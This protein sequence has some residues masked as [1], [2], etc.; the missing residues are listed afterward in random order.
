MVVVLAGVVVWMAPRA[1]ASSSPAPGVSADARGV[2]W[3]CA[4][5]E[6]RVRALFDALD[7]DRPELASAHDAIAAGDLPAACRALLARYR[8][9]PSGSWL[10]RNL[11]APSTRTD[12]RAEK[13]LGDTVMVDWVEARVPRSADGGFDWDDPGPHGDREWAWG[14]NRHTHLRW[15]CDA[16]LRTGNVRYVERLDEDLREWIV[17]SPYPGRKS[18]TARWRGPEA[19]GRV[20]EWDDI[21]YAL[22]PVDAFSPST[23]IL[24]LASLVDH[25]DYLRRFHAHGNNWAVGEMQGLALMA[26]AWPEFRDAREWIAYASEVMEGEMARQVYPDGAHTELTCSYHRITARAFE[27]FI[28]TAGRAGQVRSDALRSGAERMWSYL[29]HTIRPDGHG[30]L[31]NDSDLNYTRATVLQFADFYARDDWRFVAS[32]GAE[33][34]APARAS[35]VFPWAGH[36]VVRSGFAADAH[37]AFFD[38]GPWGTGHQHDDMLHLSVSA[39]GRDLLV[40]GGRYGYR[41]NAWRDYFTGSAAHN[42]IIVDGRGQR[43]GP[44]RADA[45]LDSTAFVW[46]EAFD[47]ARGSFDAGFRGVAG[48]A[49][50]TRALMYVRG[51]YWIVVDRID[52]DRPRQVT[53]LWHLHPDC[54]VALEGLEAVTTNPDAGNLRVVPLG[55]VDWRVTVV[56]GQNTPEIQGWY[57]AHYNQ[58]VPAPTAVYTARMTQSTT[59]AWLL[60]PAR[61]VPE[62][63]PA[64]LTADG[65]AARVRVTIAGRTS[66]ATVPT[67]AGVRP[68]LRFD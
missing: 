56:S 43:S 17:S 57:S 33:G 32:N 39:F 13:V 1:R 10:R 66:E 24:M 55:A 35:V 61:G 28:E 50:H 8:A 7:L 47:F 34:L 53:A 12:R 38:I 67:A 54:A 6:A 26:A 11:P 68:V 18:A 21:F 14:I 45:P 3:V 49:H 29:A 58:R 5:H 52:T 2:E 27:D 46:G 9:G 31:N 19:S 44:E 37:W 60:L 64:T 59:F 42:V 15:L 20:R 16:F 48:R 63:P 4:A 41:E 23:R 30:L 36:V 65:D 22:Q 62:S 25:A 40:D 51:A